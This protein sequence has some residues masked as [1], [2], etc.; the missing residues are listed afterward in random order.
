M[1][2]SPDCRPA[3][4]HA[5]TPQPESW[6]P[7][8][9]TPSAL[10]RSLRTD[11]LQAW[12]WVRGCRTL[13]S[14]AVRKSAARADVW[15]WLA[16]S[17]ISE[18]T[19]HRCICQCAVKSQRFPL[20]FVVVNK[21]ESGARR[22]CT[23]SFC[24]CFCAG[25]GTLANLRQID[26]SL[27]SFKQTPSWIFSS[28]AEWRPV[29]TLL[30][31]YPGGRRGADPASGRGSAVITMRGIFSR[32]PAAGCSLISSSFHSFVLHLR[33]RDL[34]FASSSSKRL[35]CKTEIKRGEKW[36]RK[37]REFTKITQ[38]AF[39]SFEFYAVLCE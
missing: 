23:R 3:A 2:V 8:N 36:D 9:P 34:A 18:P 10:E 24:P 16:S 5:G 11:I 7:S 25:R 38:V 32:L 22:C 1:S 30:A 39:C 37:W 28:G 33:D 26:V 13:V 15:P 21:E 20:L 17:D 35:S 27:L 12:R 29:R 14:L 4:E 6:R 19:S 31:G